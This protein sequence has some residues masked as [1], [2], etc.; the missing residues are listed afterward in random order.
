VNEEIKILIAY[1]YSTRPETGL[2]VYDSPDRLCKYK[3]LNVKPAV[4]PAFYTL[5][6]VFQA[7]IR[8]IIGH[9]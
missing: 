3:I 9:I 7:V 4:A 5:T 6:A 2:F 1:A 8:N